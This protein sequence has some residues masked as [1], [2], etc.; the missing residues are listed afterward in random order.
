MLR[1]L[2]A[3]NKCSNYKGKPDSLKPSE[4]GRACTSCLK[5]SKWKWTLEMFVHMGSHLAH[6]VWN[7]YPKLTSPSSH[8]PTALLVF[9]YNRCT[10]ELWS[11]LSRLLFQA[12]SS[13]SSP[14]SVQKISFSTNSFFQLSH[15]SPL[16]G[17]TRPSH[18]LKIILH[19]PLRLHNPNSRNP[20]PTPPPAHPVFPNSCN[21]PDLAMSL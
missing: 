9:Q 5:Y 10:F 3:E 18:L 2:P 15:E 20:T 14:P 11:S 17:K 13:G 1:E 19:L 4:Q 12:V 16:L 21:C 7:N 6:H 8:W